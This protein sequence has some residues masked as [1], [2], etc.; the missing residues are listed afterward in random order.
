MF[1]TGAGF[2]FFQYMSTLLFQDVQDIS[3]LQASIRF[4]PMVVVGVATNIVTAH[5]VSKVNV[6]LLLGASALM[7][8]ISPI[9]K[10]VASPNWTYWAAAFIAMI[11]SPINGDG[12]YLLQITYLIRTISCKCRLIVCA[13]LWAVSSLIIFGHS[14]MTQ[15]LWLGVSLTPSPSWVN[16]VGLAVTA[17]IAASVTTCI[18]SSAN[19]SSR[20][21]Q[22]GGHLLE[23]YRAAYWLV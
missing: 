14:L 23:E 22:M 5:L 9:L 7:T 10:A 11:S 8:A 21:S 17:V 12:E 13:V 18:N 2:N 20:A 19:D 16:S 15:W 4:L 1:F 3:A 6:N